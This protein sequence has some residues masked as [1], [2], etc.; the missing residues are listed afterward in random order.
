MLTQLLFHPLI[1]GFLLAAILAA[2]MSTISSQLLVSSSSLSEDFYKVFVRPGAG[3]RELVL[4][5]RLAVVM[6][7]LFAVALAWDRDT[8]I[9]SLV[10]NAWAGFGAAFGPLI[11]FS[12]FWPG[13]TRNGALAGIITGAATVLLW[14]HAPFT[15]N[16][17]PPGVVIYEIVP[18]FICSSLAI[19]WVSK[20]GVAQEQGI[21]TE[22]A[23]MLEK[24]IPPP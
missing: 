13:M 24:L 8:T 23:E 3:Q 5:S 17:Q 18:G 20:L 22:F 1:G 6:V 19:C 9:L 2:V 16:G 11:L 15:L 12:L 21:K 4:V 7:A 14:I 10:S